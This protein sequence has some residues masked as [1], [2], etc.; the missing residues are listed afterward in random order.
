MYAGCGM[1]YY[2]GAG[3]GV[4]YNYGRR[5]AVCNVYGSV[6]MN[7]LRFMVHNVLLVVCLWLV[8]SGLVAAHGVMSV[9]AALHSHL[10][11][12]AS[13]VGV[14]AF[15]AGAVILSVVFSVLLCH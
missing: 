15:N 7:H 13:S 9:V 3:C 10:L 1:V 12:V 14:T 2:N 6:V 8:R 5:V 4:V 11:A